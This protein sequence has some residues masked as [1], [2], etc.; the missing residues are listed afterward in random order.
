MPADSVLLVTY[1]GTDPWYA[2]MWQRVL[3]PRAVITFPSAG[4]SGAAMARLRA[5][6]RIQYA[7]A[8][9]SPPADPG[10]ARTQD[11]GNVPGSPDRVW[12]GPLSR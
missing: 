1:S 6:Y 5:S 3:Y 8:T 10:F 12:F 11:L 9:G 7:V 2:C 4:L